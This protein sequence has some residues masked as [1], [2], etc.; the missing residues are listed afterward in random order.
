MIYKSPAPN[1]THICINTLF[2]VHQ[3]CART[4]QGPIAK[5]SLPTDPLFLSMLPQTQIF[6][7]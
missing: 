5:K 2:E 4:C 7:F 3:V 6:C 1:L